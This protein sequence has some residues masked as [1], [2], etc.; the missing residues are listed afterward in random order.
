MFLEIIPELYDVEGKKSYKPHMA[1]GLRPPTF[2]FGL[3]V[4]CPLTIRCK[5][6]RELREFLKGCKKASDL[7]T[8]GKNEYWLPPDKFETVKQGDCDDFAL[9]T[10]RQLMQVGYP[11]RFVAGYYGRYE[12]GHCWTTFQ[13]EGKHYL[14]EPMMAIIQR[15]LPRLL[16]L[17]YR[18]IYSVEW[19][20][21]HITF[22]SHR[23]SSGRLGPARTTKLVVEWLWFWTAFFLELVPRLLVF[24]PRHVWR[25]LRQKKVRTD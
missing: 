11:A 7:D 21:K 14:A 1:K 18:P 15:K 24:G 4:N 8:F 23:E 12:I 20:G 22:C 19:D 2:P 10:W 17:K 13:R 6:L 25:R 16:I 9:W 5:D 3:Y